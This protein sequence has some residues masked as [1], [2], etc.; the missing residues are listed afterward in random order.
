MQAG[1][2]RQRE[3]SLVF[4]RTTSH[5]SCSSTCALEARLPLLYVSSMRYPPASRPRSSDGWS[6]GF[7]NALCVLRAHRA[8]RAKSLRTGLIPKPSRE[9]NERVAGFPRSSILCT[10]HRLS[11]N[12]FSPRFLREKDRL[13]LL[14]ALERTCIDTVLVA[15]VVAT[16]GEDVLVEPGWIALT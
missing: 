5:L 12:A 4:T 7:L 13:S 6:G 1:D 8:H 11:S 9:L 14:R 10:F 3:T 2:S 16:R 15:S